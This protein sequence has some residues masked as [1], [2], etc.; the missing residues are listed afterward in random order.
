MKFLTEHQDTLMD[1]KRKYT[2]MMKELNTEPIMNFVRT[3]GADWKRHALRMPRSRIPFEML[4]Y[5]PERRS[6]TGRPF[7]RWNETVTDL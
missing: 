4:L 5:E 6:S 1:H 7:K 2:L 3:Y